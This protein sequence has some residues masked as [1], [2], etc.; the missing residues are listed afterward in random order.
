MLDAQDKGS[1]TKRLVLVA[2]ASLVVGG[3]MLALL[4]HAILGMLGGAHGKLGVPGKGKGDTPVILIGDDLTFKAPVSGIPWS[5]QT[6]QTQYLVYTA[7]VGQPITAIALKDKATPDKTDTPVPDDQLA[8][9][10][11]ARFD[12]PNGATWVIY[13]YAVP[14]GSLSGTPSTPVASLAP[15]SS[16][17]IVVTALG[18]GYVCP[19]KSSV[20]LDYSFNTTCSASGQPGQPATF[21]HLTISI[22]ETDG[23]TFTGNVNCLDGN[24]TSGVCRVVFRE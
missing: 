23:T 5:Q 12:V 8:A 1:I 17:S 18:G 16:N 6:Q 20:R 21:D 13:E 10:D 3:L 4:G 14:K 24:D 11:L 22:T 19:N 9:T 15:G 2:A 7:A